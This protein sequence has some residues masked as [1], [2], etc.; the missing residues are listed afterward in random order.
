[1]EVTTQRSGGVDV[2]QVA[3]RI[4]H[5]KAGALEAAL[6]PHLEGPKADGHP[7]LLLDMAGV[8]FLT[9]AGLRVLMIAAKTCKAQQR[10][11]AVTNLQP[12][13]AEVVRI[14]RF[15]LVI[16]VYPSVADA[17]AAISPSS[18]SPASRE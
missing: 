1:M 9:S 5:E 6:S 18:S 8:S 10:P 2:I 16:P 7:P 14:S 15:D 17:M 11:I 13:I 12:M 4:D 3:G